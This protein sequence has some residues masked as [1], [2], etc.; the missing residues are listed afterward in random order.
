MLLSYEMFATGFAV[1]NEMVNA[2]PGRFDMTCP[3]WDICERYSETVSDGT[4]AAFMFW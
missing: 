1:L 4:K 3:F 2:L